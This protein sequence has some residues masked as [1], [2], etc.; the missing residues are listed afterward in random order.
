MLGIHASI[1]L[2]FS[3]SPMFFCFVFALHVKCAKLEISK[4]RLS[5]SGNTAQCLENKYIHLH[6][7]QKQ[8]V[9][10]FVWSTCICACQTMFADHCFL[11]ARFPQLLIPGTSTWGINQFLLLCFYPPFVLLI[12]SSLP[13]TFPE[14]QIELIFSPTNSAIVVAFGSFQFICIFPHYPCANRC[15]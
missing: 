11:S 6:A 10:R 14:F 5:F 12:N 2:V 9:L 1:C 4:E 8:S 7:N 15:E 13:C 3:S